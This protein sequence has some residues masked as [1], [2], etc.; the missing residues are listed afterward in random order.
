MLPTRA[1]SIGF[2]AKKPE[3]SS[4]HTA[5]SFIEKLDISID[6]EELDSC[7]VWQCLAVSGQGKFVITHT[8][9]SITKAPGT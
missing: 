6:G 7:I 1:R 8:E 5:N 9:N 4:G 3:P 2:G